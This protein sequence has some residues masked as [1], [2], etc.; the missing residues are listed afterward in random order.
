MSR[1]RVVKKVIKKF[2]KELKEDIVSNIQHYFHEEKDESLG[3]LEAEQILNFML[4]QIGPLVYNQALS[5]MRKVIQQQ[6][7]SLEEETYALEKPMAW[8][9]KGNR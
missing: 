3:N 1:E 5:D 8:G 4:Q 7:S 6:F 2:P 9:K